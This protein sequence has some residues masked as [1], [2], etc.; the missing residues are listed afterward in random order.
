MTTLQLVWF[1][2]ICVLFVGFFFLE[3]FDF[4][5]GMASGIIARTD[6]EKD[7]MLHI[8]GPH[9]V[10]NETWL[11]TAGGAMFASFPLWY[12]SLFSSYYIMFLLVLTGLILRGVSFEFAG[13]AETQKGRHFWY[14][15]F[16]FGSFF[17]PFILCMIFFSMIQGVPLDANGDGQL[18]FFDFVNWLSIVGGVAGVLMSVIH[19]LNYTRLT[20]TGILRER[21]QKL[22]RILYPVLFVGEVVFAL[23]VIFQTDFFTAKPISSTIITLLIVVMSLVGAWG[24]YQDREI[25]S[26]LGS[27]L[28][29]AFV[30]ILIFNGLF[31]R[32]MIATNPAHNI[33]IKD[34]ASSPMALQIMTIVV[35][36]LLPIVLIYFIWSYVIFAHRVPSDK[37]VVE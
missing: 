32:V 28:S 34:A 12:A 11:V 23:L 7:T 33:L 6:A 18:M 10:V 29:L 4:G 17:A 31:P 21:A 9:W 1:L 35:C 27:G 13:H 5:V 8:I 30:V 15:M 24:V 19:G 16:V 2:L 25:S 20:T 3:G 26:L 37:K 14:N 22:N 36:V